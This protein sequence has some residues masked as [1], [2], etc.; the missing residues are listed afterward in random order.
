MSTN[1]LVSVIIPTYNRVQYI[2]E[3]IDSVLAQT[4]NN[5]E[6]IVVDDGSTDNTRDIIQQYDSKVKYIF[7]NNA[8]PSAA[9]NNGIKQS[10]GELIAFLD[11]DDIWLAE[12]LELQIE[13]MRQSQYIGLVSCGIYIIDASGKIISDPV[14]KGNYKNRKSFVKELMV[15]NIIGGGSAILIK[16]ECLNRIG[17]FNEDLWVGED[18][19][20]WLRIAKNYEVKFVEK[21]LVKYRIHGN[22]LH[23]NLAKIK[24]DG[25]RNVLENIE[26]WRIISRM[27]AYSY[28][29]LD[30]AHEYMGIKENKS[31]ILLNLI[32]SISYY[33]LKTYPKDDKYKALCKYLLSR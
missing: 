29:Y 3:A 6:V 18:W 30:L 32:K 4:Y 21:P 12:K 15:H 31:K 20:M 19:N 13:L 7:Q 22:N 23:K 16:K 2:C 27:K 11:S 9:R 1:L 5:T 33:P 24:V 14:I 25:K 28:I 8:G 17:L 26:K 10:S